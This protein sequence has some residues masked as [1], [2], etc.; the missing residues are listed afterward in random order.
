MF[1]VP[2][3]AAYAVGAGICDAMELESGVVHGNPAERADHPGHGEHFGHHVHSHDPAQDENTTSSNPPQ[4]GSDHH[5]AH[6]HPVLL[7]VLFVPLAHPFQPAGLILPLPPASRY[8]SAI[9]P[10]PDRPPRPATVV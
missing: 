1:A 4:P 9:L 10:G 3:N 8:T 5:H 6:V 7:W 2:F